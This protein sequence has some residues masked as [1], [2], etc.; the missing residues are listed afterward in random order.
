MARI[1]LFLVIASLGLGACGKKSTKAPEDTCKKAKEEAASKWEEANKAWTRVHESWSDDTLL[2]E[3]EKAL[4]DRA[5]SAEDGA[6]QVAKEMVTLKSYLAFKVEHAQRLVKM[7]GAVKDALMEEPGK[8][9]KLARRTRSASHDPSLTQPSKAAWTALPA[10][11]D[12]NEAQNKTL[13]VVTEAEK[14]TLEAATAC[15]K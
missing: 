5:G 15:G 3:L 9:A 10:V 8:A 2:A 13:G 1:I 14:L 7:T 4:L 11:A 12:R 6:A